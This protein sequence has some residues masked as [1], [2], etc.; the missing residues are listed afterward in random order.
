MGKKFSINRRLEKSAVEEQQQRS[1]VLDR[2]QSLSEDN[3]LS[4]FRHD[5]NRVA[6]TLDYPTDGQIILHYFLTLI[7]MELAKG[8]RQ[9]LKS[10]RYS[11]VSDISEIVI[12]TLYLKKPGPFTK[13][14][15]W[16]RPDLPRG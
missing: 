1:Y 3:E 13:R 12:G 8:F 14:L 16:T 5:D 4:Q 2:L 9:K 6:T 7:D 15:F 10:G 11:S